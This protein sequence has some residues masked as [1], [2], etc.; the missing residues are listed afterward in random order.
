MGDVLDGLEEFEGYQAAAT[1]AGGKRLAGQDD[2]FAVAAMSLVVNA[3]KTGDG[4][5]ITR[6]MEARGIVR[7]TQN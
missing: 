2:D 5:R 4:G 6:T 7:K 1:A 3:I